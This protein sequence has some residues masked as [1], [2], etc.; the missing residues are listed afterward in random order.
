MADK[1]KEDNNALF[2]KLLSERTDKIDSLKLT[3]SV[4]AKRIPEIHQPGDNKSDKTKDKTTIVDTKA[5]TAFSLLENLIDECIFDTLLG[6]HKDLRT[7]ASVC[8][9]STHL[10]IADAKAMVSENLIVNK[11]GCDIFGNSF[12]SANLP[13]Y[14]CVNCHKMYPATRYAPHLEKCL[15]LAGR[16]SSRVASRRMGSQSPY[17]TVNQSEDSMGGSDI[18]P[19]SIEKRRRKAMGKLSDLSRLKKM[20]AHESLSQPG[21]KSSYADHIRA[22]LEDSDASDN[23]YR[24]GGRRS[25]SPKLYAEDMKRSSSVPIKGAPRSPNSDD[26]VSRKDLKRMAVKAGRSKSKLAIYSSDEDDLGTKSDLIDIDGLE[27]RRKH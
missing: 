18:E 3:Y 15:G 5:T 7:R 27:K 11:A 10:L 2:K 22:E 6:V 4:L 24:S 8:Q 25:R 12:T 14:E 17:M 21:H 19:N 26:N 20:R 13:S 9:I 1:Q 16:Q 23:N